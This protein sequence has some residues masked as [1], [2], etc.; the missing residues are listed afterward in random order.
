MGYSGLP[1]DESVGGLWVMERMNTPTPET[2][3]SM[4]SVRVEGVSHSAV[5]EDI[6]A[7]FF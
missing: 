2:R 5:A 6:L 7:F 3:F 4:S 1:R